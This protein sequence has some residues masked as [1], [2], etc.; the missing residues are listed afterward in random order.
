MPRYARDQISMIA[1]A[2]KKYTTQEMDQ[3]LV[4]CL[5]N[6]L[7]KA[8]DFEPV[9]VSLRQQVVAPQALNKGVDRLQN[10]KYKIQPHTSSI[11]DYKQIL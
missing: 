4:Y 10:P 6:N 7:P 9:L 8:V 1:S 3:T 11:S 2:G 5:E